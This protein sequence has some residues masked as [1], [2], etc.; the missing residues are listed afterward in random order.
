MAYTHFGE[1]WQ[2]GH[3]DLIVGESDVSCHVATD[4]RRFGD[5]GRRGDGL[6]QP[7]NRL[8]RTR[9]AA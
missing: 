8:D 7:G 4:A 6:A 5:D 9:K 3:R 1:R 2:P